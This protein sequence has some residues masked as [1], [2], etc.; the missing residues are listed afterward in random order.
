MLY[1]KGIPHPWGNSYEVVSRQER[2]WMFVLLELS[3]PVLILWDLL[4]ASRAFEVL[5]K[6]G[7]GRIQL[8]STVLHIPVFQQLAPASW[9]KNLLWIFPLES[10]KWE[11]ASLCSFFTC[12]SSYS[13]PTRSLLNFLFSTLYLPPLWLPLAWQCS[14]I[15]FEELGLV[16]CRLSYQHRHIPESQRIPQDDQNIPFL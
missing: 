9:K 11:R 6:H 3:P 15:L 12:L 4:A 2:R 1:Q 8:E 5:W 7:K 13:F 10:F 14:G 16:S